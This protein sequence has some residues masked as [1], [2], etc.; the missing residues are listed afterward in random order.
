MHQPSNLQMN[1]LKELGKVD[2]FSRH[3][4]QAAIAQALTQCNPQLP[5]ILEHKW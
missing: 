4:N 1:T 5:E 2:D 3:C